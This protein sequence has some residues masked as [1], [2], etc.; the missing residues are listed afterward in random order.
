M[1]IPKL[2]RKLLLSLLAAA[3]M[4]VACSQPAAH[5]ACPAPPQMGCPA[6]ALSFD[7]GIGE[8]LH[9][10]CYPCHSAD[11]VERTRQLTDYAHVSGERMSIASQLVTCSMPPAGSPPLSSSERQQILDWFACGGPE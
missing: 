3:P 7:T 9:S 2:P 5:E 1:L 4:A 11:G 10:R 6:D 8:L